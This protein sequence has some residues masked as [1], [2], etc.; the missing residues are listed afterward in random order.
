MQGEPRPPT[1]SV[2]PTEQAP[3]GGVG[4]ILF[5]IAW[6]ALQ[7]ALI[8]TAGRRHD[9]A[10]GFRMFSE[11]SSIKVVLYR[12]VRGERIHVDDGAW[13]ARDAGGTVRRFAWADRV[14]PEL[15]VF[16]REI[17][18]SYGARTQLV[19]LQGAL[20]D[21]AGHIA[22]DAETTRLFLDVTIKRNGREA[23]TFHLA[24]RERHPPGGG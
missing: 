21:V 9:G 20:D 13:F 3:L 1:P 23:E 11:S 8:S 16:D 5:A 2:H 6:I 15:G 19:R 22:D 17:N 10:F 18:A 7:I 4:R 14:R 24:S 12:E